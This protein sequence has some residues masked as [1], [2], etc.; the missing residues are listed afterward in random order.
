MGEDEIVG[1]NVAGGGVAEDCN[2]GVNSMS[3][4]ANASNVV[5]ELKS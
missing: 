1:V 3:E 5:I 4:K 2:V